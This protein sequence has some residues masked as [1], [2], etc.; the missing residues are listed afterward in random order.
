MSEDEKPE[1]K[2]SD[3]DAVEISDDGEPIAKM[4]TL[5]LGADESSDSKEGE[6]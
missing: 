5:E 2:L 1:G 3:S 4:D 6:S